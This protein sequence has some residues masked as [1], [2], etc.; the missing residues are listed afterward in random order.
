MTQG[1][2]DGVSSDHRSLD[3]I[4]KRK[5][6]MDGSNRLDA[7]SLLIQSRGDVLYFDETTPV[8][9]EKKLPLASSG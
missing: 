1:M 8:F 7:R 3:E 4:T 9:L 5:Q 2:Y 6:T